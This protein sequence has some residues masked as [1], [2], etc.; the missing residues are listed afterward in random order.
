MDDNSDWFRLWC[1][2]ISDQATNSRPSNFAH[3]LIKRRIR[4]KHSKPYIVI[5]A[6]LLL[7]MIRYTWADDFPPQD[8]GGNHL[9]LMEGDR[10]WGTHTNVDS[11]IV[12]G[13]FRVLDYDGVTTDSGTLI[14]N[15]IIIEIEGTMDLSGTGYSGSGGGS[16]SEYNDGEFGS[17]KYPVHP[18]PGCNSVFCADGP[19]PGFFSGTDGGYNHPHINSDS[20]TDASL[21]MGSGGASGGGGIPSNPFRNQ[22]G[23]GGGGGGGCGGG[24]VALFAEQEISI[25]GSILTKGTTGQNGGAGTDGRGCVGGAGITCF[26]GDG[27]DGGDAWPPGEGLGGPG[28]GGGPDPGGVPGPAGFPGGSGAGGGILLKCDTPGGLSIT[29]LLDARGGRDQYT[30]GGTVK[31][32]T[33]DPFQPSPGTIHAGRVYIATGPE[34]SG[35]YLY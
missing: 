27:G 6:L 4:L 16:G 21:F 20:T 11:L 24:K 23:G 25:T 1:R 17:Q 12:T 28:G 2:G 18:R 29:G 9:I 22:G 13:Y 34:V 10:I 5:L 19:A 35:W 7:P 32:F 8:H 15:A 26:R 3:R 31:I 33:P 14:I 30:N